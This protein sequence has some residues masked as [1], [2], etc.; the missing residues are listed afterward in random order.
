MGGLTSESQCPS[1]ADRRW[2][3]RASPTAGWWHS[4]RL[5]GQIPFNRTRGSTRHVNDSQAL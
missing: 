1:G 3:R 2:A 4:F 5:P